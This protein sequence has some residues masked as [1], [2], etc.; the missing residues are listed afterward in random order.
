MDD[1][2]QSH[3]AGPPSSARASTSAR[4]PA[5]EAHFEAPSP[6][7]SDCCAVASSPV[8]DLRGRPFARPAP[9]GRALAGGHWR[10]A[11]SGPRRK[12][13]TFSDTRDGNIT[14]ASLVTDVPAFR[15]TGIRA[16]PDPRCVRRSRHPIRVTPDAR[17]IRCLT[18]ATSDALDIRPRT[19]CRT[20]S[21]TRDG[22]IT[23][24]PLV[25]DVPAFRTIAT[26]SAGRATSVAGSPWE[27]G[28]IGTRPG[29]RLRRRREICCFRQIS[30][31]SGADSRI[32]PPSLRA[33]GLGLSRADWD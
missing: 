28:M 13:R 16:A 27:I 30:P 24:V 20:F 21:H 23:L 14:P 6:H 15:T 4:A 26:G 3:R 8:R 7:A 9:A 1:S 17:T 2:P 31:P 11:A 25:T 32:V 5:G 29:I 22:C 12:C 19:K 18:P 10:P 33:T